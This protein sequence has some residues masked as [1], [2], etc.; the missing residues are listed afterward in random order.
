MHKDE[1]DKMLSYTK[2]KLHIAIWNAAIE[3]VIRYYNNDEF[4]RLD[5]ERLKK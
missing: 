2:H 5:L 4:I 3:A 1:V